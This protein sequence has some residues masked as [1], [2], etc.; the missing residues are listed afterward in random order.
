MTIRMVEQS[1]RCHAVQCETGAIDWIGTRS[2]ACWFEVETRAHSL[3]GVVTMGIE[4]GP[5]RRLEAG[6]DPICSCKHSC[7]TIPFVGPAQRGSGRKPVSGKS[8]KEMRDLVD[9]EL[10][11]MTAYVA[12][13][14]APK[15][16]VDLLVRDLKHLPSAPK[17][18]P[19][20]KRLL[21]DGNSSMDEI[22]MLI[23]LDPGM[24]A[25]VL[26]VGNSLYYSQSVRCST[27]N[28]AVH[29]VGFDQVYELVSYSVASQVLVRPLTAY[30]IEADDLWKLSVAGAL[31]AETLA[32]HT[33]QDRD[34]AYTAGLLHCLGM[35]A[36][37]DWA[38]RHRPDLRLG[39]TGFPE[40]ATRAEIAALGFTQADAGAALL[41]YWEFPHAMCE[42][43]QWQ[44]SPRSSAVH[45]RM[46]CL[47]YCAKWLRSQVCAA[48]EERPPSIPESVLQMV[49][50]RAVELPRLVAELEQKLNQISSLLE[51]GQISRPR[52]SARFPGLNAPWVRP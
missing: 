29:R 35:V 45:T 18:L 12:A 7:D 6:G 50:L 8:P 20:L 37:D 46:A 10:I 14:A 39:S 49:P 34:V 47:L 3:V 23:R 19:R 28:E 16:A 1:R 40:E 27:V 31:A 4:S 2:H 9:E 25:R 17:V 30:G 44:Y 52:A 15:I 13:T 33:G 24:A 26:Q 11:A 48:A 51:I 36:I 41:R 42:P 32:M 43:V 38:L 21:T 22:V 5:G